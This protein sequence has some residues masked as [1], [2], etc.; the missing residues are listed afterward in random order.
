MGILCLRN[1]SSKYRIKGVDREILK[2]S[3]KARNACNTIGSFQNIGQSCPKI[4]RSGGYGKLN[5]YGM[6]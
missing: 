1:G 3:L 4:H 5:G 2:F 6:S